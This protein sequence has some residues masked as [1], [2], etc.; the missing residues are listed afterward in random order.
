ML[1]ADGSPHHA[2]T[3]AET[4]V[5]GLAWSPDARWVSYT[6][7]PANQ[8][9][10]LVAIELATDHVVPLG[11]MRQSVPGF[12]LWTPVS[13]LLVVSDLSCC[14]GAWTMSFRLVAVKGSSTRL[15]EVPV[16]DPPGYAMPI[17][18]S[19]ALV[20]R[21]ASRD[22]RLVSLSDES[23]ERVLL[24]NV[25]LFAAPVVSSDRQWLAVR[26]S[27]DPL[28]AT[29]LNVIELCRVDG[30]ARTTTVLPFRMAPGAASLAILPGAQA[31]LVAEAWGPTADPGVYLV[32]VA[33]KDLRKLFTYPSRPGRSGPPD[34]A[35]SADG[36]TVAAAMW[37]GMKPS[38]TTI[39]LSTFRRLGRE[40]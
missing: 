17:V 25:E 37:D 23:P 5:T 40:R 33:A 22:V 12:V 3:L 14:G 27:A 34:L 29:G 8:A 6:G 32:P 26:R 13:V 11:D 35:M 38:F 30:S 24:T 19:T 15:R 10:H 28:D 20:S 7:A 18:A 36:H 2:L 4:S 16:G 21:T 9:P 31:F 39:D 1:N